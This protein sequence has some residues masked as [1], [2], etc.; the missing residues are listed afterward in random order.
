VRSQWADVYAGVNRAGDE[1]F[2]EIAIAT[3]SH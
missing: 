1:R 3:D 2:D